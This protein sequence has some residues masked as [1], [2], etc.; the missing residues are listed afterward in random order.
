[1]TPA[2]KAAVFDLDGTLIDSYEAIL[3]CLN[4]VRETYGKEP[5]S[6]EECRRLVGHGLASLVARAI[7]EEH[8]DAGVR[9]FRERYAIVGP[10]KTS[11]LPEAD[12]V[13][14]ALAARGVPM[15]IASNKPSAFSRQ[16]ADALGIGS[17][18]ASVVG[19]DS[20]FPPKPDPAMVHHALTVMGARP[21]ETLF[22]GDMEVDVATA[23]AAG[24]KVAVVPT[25]SCTREEL[26]TAGADWLLGRLSEVL[27]LF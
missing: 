6:L 16:L 1:M 2:F 9:L 5:V 13:T 19:P 11:L 3:E 26:E 7:G 21:E 20:G 18:F 12:A 8:A 15:A 14:A 17:R 25:G 10:E 23:H 22:V 27:T 4:L 24:M